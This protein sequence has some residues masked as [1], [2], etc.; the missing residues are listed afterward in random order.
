M[1]GS[2]IRRRPNRTRHLS[3]HLRTATRRF[4]R[5]TSLSSRSSFSSDM[6]L[7]VYMRV[8]ACVCASETSWQTVFARKEGR[9]G[10]K[11]S[12]C[13]CGH[14]ARAIGFYNYTELFYYFFFLF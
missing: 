11:G 2:L 9:E 13:V 3:R 7:C 6:C 12:V 1:L 14:V 10:D 5:F 4:N 8:Y